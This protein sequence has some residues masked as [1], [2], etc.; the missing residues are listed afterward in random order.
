MK[1]DGLKCNVS[2]D[3]SQIGLHCHGEKPSKKVGFARARS[4]YI[5][6]NFS[7][8]VL[9]RLGICDLGSVCG[10]YNFHIGIVLLL[11]RV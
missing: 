8:Q 10:D 1:S 3:E 2:I 6:F 9:S 7:S 11:L 4:L 5:N